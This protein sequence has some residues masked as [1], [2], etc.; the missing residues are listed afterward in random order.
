MKNSSL[1]ILS[2][3]LVLIMLSLPVSA[4]TAPT[5]DGQ[6]SCTQETLYP[7]V[8]ATEYYLEAGYKYSENGPQFLRV[9]EFDPKQEDL[10]F[11]V[12]MA[13]PVATKKPVTQIVEE[14][15]KTNTENKKTIAA[16]NGDLWMMAEYNSRV[17]GPGVEDPVV[18]KELC[19]PRGADICDGEIICSQNIQEETPFEEMFQTFGITSDG[20][21]LIGN[22]R[23]KLKLTDVTLGT[24]SYTTLALN[25]LPAK[26]AVVVYS[27][28][29]PV[30]NYCLDDAYE[31]VVDCDYDYKLSAGSTIT[32]TVTAISEPNTARPE[33][34]ENRLIL[35]ARGDNAISKISGYRIGDEIKLETTLTDLYG[36]NEKWQTVQEAVGGHYVALKDGERFCPDGMYR[37]DPMTLIG[38]KPDG[39]V[40]IIV[41][42]GRQDWYSAGIVRSLYA[43]LCLDLGLDSV[44]LLDG[45]GST[46][47]VELTEQGYAL[48]N[49]PSDNA[50]QNIPGIER[51]VI[52][53]VIISRIKEEGEEEEPVRRGDLDGDGKLTA[54]D[55]NLLKQNVLG[56][57]ANTAASDVDGDGKV[58]AT[59]VN[60]LKAMVL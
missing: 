60:A 6:I 28:K 50:A 54:K 24:K 7:G 58:T 26:N 14:F 5:I 10:A 47:L 27:D 39:K 44:F 18:K 48:K 46:T 32:G 2:V 36:N 37:Y 9:L 42:D 20:E 13:G 45:G 19:V 43:D 53:A 29:G 22:L 12:V 49:R 56:R 25:R 21:P 3:L 35:T 17:E 23:V 40:V 34:Q 31:V 59:D 41:N 4:E 16:V 30:S 11:D 52:N 33:M 8:T 51:A 57:M 15:N 1:K 55:V 38:F